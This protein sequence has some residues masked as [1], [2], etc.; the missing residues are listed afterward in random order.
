MR[1]FRFGVS[2]RAIGERA[3]WVAKCRRA[4]ELGYDVI[5][6]PDHLGGPAPLPALAVAAAVTEHVRVGSL[7]LN[8]PFYN[9]ALLARDIVSTARLTGDRLDLGLGAGHMKAEFDEAGLPWLPAAG[10]VRR[11]EATLGELRDRI[12]AETAMPP[13]LL[14][15]HGDGTLGLAADHADIAGFSGLR[16]APGHSP[17]TFLLAGAEEMDERVAFFRERAGARAQHVELN[18]LVQ[19]VAVTGDRREAAARWKALLPQR[20]LD[21]DE[22][23]EAPQ[24]LLGERALLAEQLLARRERYGFSYV[25]VFEPYLE[26]FAPVL[27][28]LKGR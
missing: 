15:G 3:E 8:V 17:G 26:E 14:A 4:E 20:I 16:H 7:V 13:I 27:A 1:E 12:G 22:L 2:M 18:M 10:R 25:T 28:E 11:L 21:V 23:L 24:L 6:V 19:H 5:T 9:P